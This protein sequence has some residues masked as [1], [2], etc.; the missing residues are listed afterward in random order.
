MIKLESKLAIIG[1]GISGLACATQLKK[2]GFNVTIFEKS[3]GVSG[4]MST[5]TKDDWQCDHGAQYFT[6]SDGA[7]AAEVQR[8]QQAGVADVWQPI[9]Q[10]FDGE[11]FSVK[12]STKVRYVGT[13]RQTSPA[14]WLAQSLNVQA[15]TTINQVNFINNQ[16]QLASN[17]HGAITQTFDA[18]ILAIPSVQ[19]QALLQISAPTLATVAA[20]VKMQGCWTLMC[21]FNDALNLPFDGLFITNNLLSWV[22]RDSAKPGRNVNNETWVLHASNQWSEAHIEDDAETV[23]AQMIGAL[24]S[25][26]GKMPQT[27]TAH[28]WRYADCANYLALGNVWDADLKLGLCGDWLNGGKVQGAWLSGH[29]LAQKL[30]NN[31]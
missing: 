24:I 23:A 8:W 21:R 11:N 25:L 12:K 7:F 19:A 6:A 15:A 18:L 10:A 2:L 9:L 1:A 27:Y 31:W 14:K 28:R 17:E 20:S 16:W 26:G 3:K 4:R 29:N 22:A 5:R 13:P 30:V